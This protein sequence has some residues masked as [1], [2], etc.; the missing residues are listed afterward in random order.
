VTLARNFL[1]MVTETTRN[2]LMLRNQKRRNTT[3]EDRDIASALPH[4][5]TSLLGAQR[6]LIVGVTVLTFV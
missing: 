6:Q 5:V 2:L 3:A 4:T 1:V